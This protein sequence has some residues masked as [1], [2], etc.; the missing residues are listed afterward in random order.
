MGAWTDG[1]T[2]S[3]TDGRIDEQMDRQAEGKT[4]VRTDGQTVWVGC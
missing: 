3:H 2:Y 1:R 4:Y